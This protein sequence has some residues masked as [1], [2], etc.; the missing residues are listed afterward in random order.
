M[1]T[2]KKKIRPCDF[3][4]NVPVEEFHLYYRTTVF[5]KQGEVH[6]AETVGPCNTCR[7]FVKFQPPIWCNECWEAKVKE[8]LR[9]R[10]RLLDEG[11]GPEQ[12]K[13]GQEDEGDAST[14]GSINSRKSKRR[15]LD[16]VGS[17]NDE[18]REGI[19]G[20]DREDEGASPFD[21][22]DYAEDTTV[23][24]VDNERT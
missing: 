13:V 1:T 24:L 21:E 17:D 6:L 3:D 15:K 2:N 8:D 22:T 14:D 9:E 19:A 7:K 10:K 23:E 11:S 4:D 16:E 5:Y 20:E 12:D 18:M